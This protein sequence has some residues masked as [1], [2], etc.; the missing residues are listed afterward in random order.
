MGLLAW[1]SVSIP[2]GNRFRRP[3]I[4]LLLF[5]SLEL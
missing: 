3:T 4:G 1:T 2:G 5:V